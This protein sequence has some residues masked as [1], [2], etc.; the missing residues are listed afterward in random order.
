[1]LSGNGYVETRTYDRAG[2]LTDVQNASGTN[3]LSEFAVTRDAVGN[4]I[5]V[6]RTGATTSTAT[7]TYD[8]NDRLTGVC[9]Q[10]TCPNS[11]DPAIVWTYDK[12]GNRLSETRPSGTTNYTY[13]PRDELTQ[14]GSTSYAYDN[15]GNEVTAG[16]KTYIYDLNNR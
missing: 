3:V 6:N 7:Y 4:P 5:E 13:N 2:R 14:V 12:V 10:S 11:S 9:F 1:L 15:N 8:A 16:S